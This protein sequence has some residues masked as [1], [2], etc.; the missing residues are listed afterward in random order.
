MTKKWKAV[1]NDH[2]DLKNGQYNS[3]DEKYNYGSQNYIT[4]PK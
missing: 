4:L 1:K 2:K 3:R